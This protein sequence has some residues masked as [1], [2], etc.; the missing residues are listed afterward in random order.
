MLKIQEKKTL[1]GNSYAIVKFSDLSRVFELFVFSDVFE[2]NRE[3]LIE[4]NSLMI[5]L[6]KNFTDENRY[7]ITSGAGPGIMEAANKG[8]HESGG[9]SI[10]LGIS[11]PFEQTNNKRIT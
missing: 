5:T 2:T 11:L 9:M 6:M 4:G 1:K 3:I 7:V 8:A 10:G